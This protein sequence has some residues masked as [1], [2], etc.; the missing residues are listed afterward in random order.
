MYNCSIEQSY[1]QASRRTGIIIEREGRPTEKLAFTY[2]YDEMSRLTGEER[3]R[4]GLP[5]YQYLW[6]YDCVGNRTLQV[7]TE[8]GVTQTTVYEYSEADRLRSEKTYSGWV[9]LGNEISVVDY[10]HDAEGNLIWKDDNG[11]V[12]MYEWDFEN[13]N[14]DLGPYTSKRPGAHRRRAQRRR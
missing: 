7:H 5:V 13:R 9:S 4:A 1:H 14:R 11:Q 6:G 10:D 3:I 2:D 8:A 12:T